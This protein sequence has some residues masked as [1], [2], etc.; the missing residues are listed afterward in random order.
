MLLANVGSMRSNVFN[1]VTM[2]AQLDLGM[3]FALL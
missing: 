3:P 1:M 2:Y